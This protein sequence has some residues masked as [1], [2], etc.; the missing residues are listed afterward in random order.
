MTVATKFVKISF[1]ISMCG[2]IIEDNRTDL[3]LIFTFE[4]LN[5]VYY[6]NYF[7]Y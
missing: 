3:I 4:L 5:Y 7:S 6:F 2:N 1:I